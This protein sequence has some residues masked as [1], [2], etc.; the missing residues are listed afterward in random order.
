MKPLTQPFNWLGSKAR[1]RGR[2]LEILATIPRKLYVEPFGG[3]ASIFFG[4]EPEI[5]VYNDINGLLTNFF[6]K[7]RSEKDR[8]IIRGLAIYTPMCQ[9]FWREF[10]DVCKAYHTKNEKLLQTALEKANLAEYDKDIAVA[11]AFFYCQSLSFGG[12]VLHSYGEHLK[13]DGRH[14]HAKRIA[15]FDEYAERLAKTTITNCD[16]KECIEKRDDPQT[17]FYCDP[18][19]ESDSTGDYKTNWTSNDTSDL[20]A[21]LCGIKGSAVLSCY[22]GERY[23]PLLDAGYEKKDFPITASFRSN[24]KRSERDRVETIYWRRAGANGETS[25]LATAP[26]MSK[27][28]GDSRQPLLF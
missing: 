20:V 3:S 1:M 24:Y 26:F 7:L 18:P 11:F 28:R 15:L 21:I 19:Y 8:E 25:A 4:K 17:L 16:F 10:K 14:D 13:P 2:V 27:P 23:K 12:S 6:R 5:S 9:I 22:D